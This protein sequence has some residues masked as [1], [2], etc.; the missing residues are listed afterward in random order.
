[1]DFLTLDTADVVKKVEQTLQ[2]SLYQTTRIVNAPHSNC[3]DVIATSADHTKSLVT[4]VVENIDTPSKDLLLELML[5]GY[6]LRATPLLL[7]NSNRRAELENNTIY[8]RMDGHIIALNL[9]TFVQ[10]IKNHVHPQKIAQR[11][12]YMYQIDG[13]KLKNLREENNISRK[14]FSDELNLSIKTIAEYER[15]K[16]VNSQVHHVE[17]MEQ[18]LQTELKQPVKIFNLPKKNKKIEQNRPSSNQNNAEIA[19]EIAEKLSNLNIFQFWTNNSPFDVFLVIPG[20]ETQIQ[21]VSG[22]FSSIHVETLS[23]LCQIAQIV[24][25]RNNLGAVSAIVED[26]QDAK[27]CKKVGVIPIESKKLISASEPQE[28]VKILSNR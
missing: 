28:I 22:I 7:G 12:G 6:F 18:L 19:H 24:K 13:E 8:F 21:A 16:F 26:R 25:I 27:E 3:C 17:M 2:E 11:G 14:I 20:K 1:M 10:V 5:L 9:N 15:H 4:K 23:R